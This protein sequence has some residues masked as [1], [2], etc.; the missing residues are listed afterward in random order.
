MTVAIDRISAAPVLDRLEHIGLACPAVAVLNAAQWMQFNKRLI[1]RRC[2]LFI[3]FVEARHET[4][5]THADRREL[6]C[7]TTSRR[8]GRDES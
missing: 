7:N 8:I 6:P 3:P 4:Q 5:L 1:G 2:V